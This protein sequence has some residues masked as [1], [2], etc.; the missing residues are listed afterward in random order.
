[1]VVGNRPFV[2]VVYDVD[3][4][5]VGKVCQYLRRFLNWVQ[6]SAFEGELNES[7]LT[8]LKHGLRA[9]IDPDYD[10]VYIYRIPAGCVVHREVIG[11]QRGATDA[12]ID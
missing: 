4:R 7:Q 5:R 12:F 2:I 11:Q 9:L 8:R 10:S 6:N 1:M 3:Q